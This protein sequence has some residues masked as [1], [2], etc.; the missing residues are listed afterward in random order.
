MVTNMLI[1]LTHGVIKNIMKKISSKIVC[2][3]WKCI[4]EDDHYFFYDL[5]KD[6]GKM[7]SPFIVAFN[8][9]SNIS[10]VFIKKDKAVFEIKNNFEY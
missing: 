2:L 6:S 3:Q 5:T 10:V 7:A 4:G 8:K 9:Y 1:R